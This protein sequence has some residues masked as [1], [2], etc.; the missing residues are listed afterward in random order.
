MSF[1]WLTAHFL[2]RPWFIHAPLEVHLD[3]LQVTAIMHKAV[4]NICAGCFVE[5]SFQGLWVNAT[6]CL[7]LLGCVTV[8]GVLESV[9]LFL[10]MAMLTCFPS[11]SE[12]EF[13][14]L[15]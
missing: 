14:S 15:P 1:S 12:R 11:S 3:D 9:K 6:G 13:G 7:L 10:K 2:N 4:V 8:F 5:M